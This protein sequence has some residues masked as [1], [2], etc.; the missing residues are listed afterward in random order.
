MSMAMSRHAAPLLFSCCL[1]ASACG[2]A[3]PSAEDPSS[4]AAVA[5]PAAS[6][7]PAFDP[8]SGEI[9]VS[10]ADP[11]WGNPDAPVTLVQFGDFG[12]AFSAQQAA[13]IRELRRRYRPEELRIV[14]KSVPQPDRLDAR[15][16]AEAALAVHAAGGAKAFWAFYDAAFA[17]YPELSA[18]HHERWASKA[19]VSG[20]RYRSAL[21]DPRVARQVEASAALADALELSAPHVLVNGRL[22][23][24][25][26]SVEVFTRAIDAEW[27]E[28]REVVARGVP[29]ARV[30]AERTRE[31]LASGAAM[32][33]GARAGGEPAEPG[34]QGA[35]EERRMFGARH[36][37][38]MYVG[39]RRALPT[40]TRTKDEA[41][42]RAEEALKKARKGVP[43]EDVVR[44]YSDE[45][46]AAARGGDLGR[47]PKG[48]M[49]PE[50][51]AELVRT[52]VGQVSGVV[53]TPFGFHVLL[54]TQ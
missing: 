12:N 27:A 34:E 23:M 9:P 7:S 1:L 44:E 22:V 3:S 49:V 20:E 46:G 17:A 25:F 16:A 2:G 39:S 18:A 19:G 31:N 47:F 52:P 28:A 42:A 13:W 40:I 4:A 35:V 30:A 50:F 43:F 41:R 29:R 5:L 15:R 8:A 54:R 51:E 37:M 21:R 26:S 33:S 24:G 6:A 48:A 38:V 45:P 11:I 32:P 36:L 53:E 10:D 14:W